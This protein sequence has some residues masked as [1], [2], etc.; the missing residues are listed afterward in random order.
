MTPALRVRGL[1]HA[2][3]N[4]EVLHGVD[5]DVAPATTLAVLGPSGCGKTTLLRLLAGF[6]RPTAGRVEISGEPVAGPDRWVPAER[7]PI[8]YVAQEG[9]LFPH[10]TVRRNLQFGLDRASRRLPHVV[11]D[12]L[13]LMSLDPSLLDRY[14]HQLSGGQQQRVALARTLAR[15]P[16][17]VLL[18]EPFSALD[19]DLR[20]TT[21]TAMSDAL[22]A[23]KVTT[24]LVTHDQSEALSF[25]NTLAIMVG[26]HFTQVGSAAEIYE[27]PVDLTTARLVGSTVV[28]PGVVSGDTAITALG[29]LALRPPVPP[30]GAAQ[31][32]VRPEQITVTAEE[33][34]DAVVTRAEYFGHDQVLELSWPAS[35]LRVR[36]RV[37]GSA[38]LIVGQR[39]TPSVV[40]SGLAFAGSPSAASDDMVDVEQRQL[41]PVGHGEV[42]SVPT[43]VAL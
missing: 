11:A 43:T 2:Y 26:G 22:Q 20:A 32:M 35:G 37:A 19:A 15:R 3:G 4:L 21:R 31:I 38:G 40:G 9:S 29:R 8:G 1:R 42:G 6:E 7:R 23:T 24:V 27:H 25:A 17:L 10:L 16:A 33:T 18:D 14:P 36:A 5:L 13:E 28:V 12:L 30:S 39:V 41:A 34:G